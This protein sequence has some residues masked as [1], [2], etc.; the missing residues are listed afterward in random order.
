M[1]KWFLIGIA[2]LCTWGMTFA[3]EDE[4]DNTPMK[5]GIH[6][7]ACKYV[8]VRWEGDK[9]TQVG[10]DTKPDCF[11]MFDNGEGIDGNERYSK[12]CVDL[13]ESIPI[14]WGGKRDDVK[15]VTGDSGVDLTMSYVSLIYKFGS[16]MIGFI[17]VL[18][19]VVSG[20]Q[21]IAGGMS[22]DGV[23]QAKTRILAAVMS[24]VLLLSTVM[25]LKTI[26]PN[27]FGS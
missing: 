11:W 15:S 17:C 4:T 6:T 9:L 1:K 19:I 12:Y 14:L 24:I 7:N 13:N 8:Q 21:I 22:P 25:I 10:C 27:F 5:Q 3:Q 2:L 18:I 20:V 26:N 23:S 16:Y